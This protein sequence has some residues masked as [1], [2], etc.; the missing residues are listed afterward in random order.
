MG[1]LSHEAVAQYFKTKEEQLQNCPRGTYDVVLQ[2]E[3]AVSK[4]LRPRA[5]RVFPKFVC[6]SVSDTALGLF[7]ELP[8]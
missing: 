5:F 4:T 7:E 6:R 2:S 3:V 8:L 1:G